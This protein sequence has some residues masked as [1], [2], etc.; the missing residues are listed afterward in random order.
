MDRTI[1]HADMNAFYAS[2]ECLYHPEI[3]NKPVAVCGDVEQR[4]G[5]VLAKNQH[6]KKYDI[7]T[8]EA[9]WQAKQK[10]HDLVTV[11][12]HY[13]LYMQFSSAAR[14]IYERYTNQIEPFG[15]D[16]CWLDVSGSLGIFTS[17]ENIANEIRNTIKAELGVTASVGVSWNKI[18]AKLGSDYKKPDA[19]TLIDREN[20]KEKFWSLPASDLLYVG[21][22]TTRKLA[23]Y[24]I[25]TIGQLA[26]T[27]SNFLH[28]KLGK[29][30]EYLWSFA[31]GHDISPVAPMGYTSPIKSIGNSMTTYRDVESYEEA[32]QVII[33]L[34]ESV[35]RRLR[36]NGFRCKTV[37][38]SVRFADLSWVERQAKLNTP[39]CIVRELATAATQ[40]FKENV[41]FSKL[42]RAIGVRACDLVGMDSGY[43][44]NFFGDTKRQERWESIE[45][46]VDVLRKRF[47]TKAVTRAVLMNADIIGES[48]PLTHDVHPVAFFR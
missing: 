1:I 22:S 19:T 31:T 15:L 2:V 36:E 7:K 14:K 3:R 6:A 45:S 9:I 17:G 10:C 41:N 47:G 21:R 4:H 46:C 18:F 33:S 35:A 42:I 5:I 43:Q 48:D 44:M 32:W 25:H 38:I 27:D 26:E 24:G 20:Y 39:S 30:G 37:Q 34:S 16:E 29:W 13:D 28:Q 12:A 11:S 8:G 40:L 23:N